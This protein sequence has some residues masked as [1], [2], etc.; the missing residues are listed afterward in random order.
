LGDDKFPI[1]LSLV[2]VIVKTDEFKKQMADVL[3]LDKNTIT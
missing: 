2:K 1:Y 3:G